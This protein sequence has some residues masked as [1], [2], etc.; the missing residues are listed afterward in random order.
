MVGASH[1][2]GRE[3]MDV[4][5]GRGGLPERQASGDQH[6]Q[7]AAGPS[8]QLLSA[9]DEVRQ[10]AVLERTKQIDILPP[11]MV[12]AVDSRVPGAQARYF[13]SSATAGS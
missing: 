4:K 5:E 8:P 2:E 13:A 6:M 3:G 1:W 12:A 7:E 10:D 9:W 11:L